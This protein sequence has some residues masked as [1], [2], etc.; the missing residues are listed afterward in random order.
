[1]V[2]IKRKLK[3]RLI[4]VW[5]IPIPTMAATMECHPISKIVMLAELM[6]VQNRQCHQASGMTSVQ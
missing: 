6:L 2:I 5:K 3:R 4:E 1:M